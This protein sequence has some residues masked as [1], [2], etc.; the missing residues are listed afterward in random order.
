VE[1]IRRNS[2][3]RKSGE[4]TGERS[5]EEE[6]EQSDRV[7]KWMEHFLILTFD[8]VTKLTRARAHHIDQCGLVWTGHFRAL[9]IYSGSTPE[10]LVTSSSLIPVLCIMSDTFIQL[11]V[12][13][14]REFSK[15]EL[16]PPIYEDVQQYTSTIFI[17]KRRG[18]SQKQGRLAL[19]LGDSMAA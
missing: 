12:P 11:S 19:L 14:Y 1:N 10:P 16:K 4:A 6:G 17:R 13:T 3:C 9:P 15:L 7:K 2:N 5:T 8:H 18:I